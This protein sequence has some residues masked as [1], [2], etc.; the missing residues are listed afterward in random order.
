MELYYLIVMYHYCQTILQLVVLFAALALGGCASLE[1]L[2]PDCIV[3]GPQQVVSMDM[4]CVEDAREYKRVETRMD[5]VACQQLADAAGIIWVT[6]TR[7]AMKRDRDG[8]PIHRS[9]MQS[10]MME[11]GCR[12][13]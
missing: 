7:G 9:D 13:N 6:I 12:W 1:D 11:N 4:V 3:V 5:Y 8:V 10:D 2:Y